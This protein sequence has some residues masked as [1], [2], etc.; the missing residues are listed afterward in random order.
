MVKS[1][2][3]DDAIVIVDAEPQ[4]ID[5]EIVGAEVPQHGRVDPGGIS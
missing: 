5:D 4:M 1:E 2:P 3:E